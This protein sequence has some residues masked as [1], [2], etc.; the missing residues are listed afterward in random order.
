MKSKLQLLGAMGI[1]G[2]IGIFVKYI[3]LP[4]AA[5]AFARG[6]LGVI[7]LL[8][9]M[10][11]TRQKPAWAAIR[12][13]L[14]LLVLS[15]AAIGINWVL[16]FESYR[17]TSVAVATICY[18]LAPLF[19]I[20]MSPLLGERL[21]GKKFLCIASAFGGMVL[22]SGVTE[23]A[24]ITLD[25]MQGILLA[26]GAAVFYATV[27]LLNKKLS[28]ISA[29]DKTIIQ[30]AAAS[31]VIL[32]YLLITGGFD[33]TELPPLGWVL[34]AVVG[35]VHT[36]FAYALYFGSMKSLP[37]HTIAIFSYLDPVLAVILSALVLQESLRVTG[38]IGAVL[39]LGSAM[40]SELPERKKV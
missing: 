29:Y 32:P 10:L 17:Y 4:S 6:I 13:N 24:A 40:Y 7:F 36:G 33:F 19:L 11:F 23:G 31:L 35:I 30:L 3:P 25:Q 12:K 21:T 15:G 1:F 37:A 38:I 9:A 2:T 39:I 22:L 14:L 20:L 34:L 28:P 18:Y 5:I 27:M 8:L 16:L 26:T